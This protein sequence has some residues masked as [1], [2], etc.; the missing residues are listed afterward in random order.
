MNSDTFPSSDSLKSEINR[1]RSKLLGSSCLRSESRESGTGS[2][3]LNKAESACE[4]RDQIHTGTERKLPLDLDENEWVR[5]TSKV[6]SF[7]SSKPKEPCD[8][9]N[10]SANQAPNS[11]C[12][13]ENI[14][15]HES[16]YPEN[17]TC[18]S[19]DSHFGKSST[20]ILETQ[21]KKQSEEDSPHAN[22]ATNWSHAEPSL[23]S[24]EVSV[25]GHQQ[26][27]QFFSLPAH[28]KERIFETHQKESGEA[29]PL[30]RNKDYL[31]RSTYNLS[32]SPISVIALK[33]ASNG[34]CKCGEMLLDKAV[35]EEKL[36]AILK[37]EEKDTPLLT[38]FE[39]NTSLKTET[40]KNSL[41][42]PPK[43]NGLD[44]TL[45]EQERPAARRRLSKTIQ[46]LQEKIQKEIESNENISLNEKE[47]QKR[48]PEPKRIPTKL[49]SR[50]VRER[51]RRR[52]K[53]RIGFKVL[54][55]SHKH[56]QVQI[57]ER[58][59]RQWMGVGNCV[60]YDSR[61]IVSSNCSQ[62]NSLAH[63]RALTLA[64]EEGERALE[65]PEEG[66]EHLTKPADVTTINSNQTSTNADM[67]K[68]FHSQSNG[69]PDCNSDKY[70]PTYEC[71][72]D[73]K[74]PVLG[75][76][77]KVTHGENTLN[78]SPELGN[79][80][81]N[82]SLIPPTYERSRCIRR[83]S[84]HTDRRIRPPTPH[85]D[86]C[87]S[88]TNSKIP[89]SQ[90]R[91]RA[92][93]RKRVFGGSM[94]FKS[95][96][97]SA[98]SVKNIQRKSNDISGESS[99]TKSDFRDNMRT[100]K[101]F[102]AASKQQRKLTTN[103]SPRKKS[104]NTLQ[105]QTISASSKDAG[106]RDSVET[107]CSDVS[108]T[109]RESSARTESSSS[110]YSKDTSSSHNDLAPAHWDGQLSPEAR[111][112]RDVAGG[113]SRRRPGADRASNNRRYVD[114]QALVD[115]K[116][117]LP[118]QL[119]FCKGQIIKQML[120]SSFDSTEGMSYGYYRAGPFKRKKKGLFPSSCVTHVSH[121]QGIKD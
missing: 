38:P 73:T 70:S 79:G 67:S 105:N 7:G 5:E 60:T 69:S 108:T 54:Q 11:I 112:A 95:Q 76:V 22:R 115:F 93:S 83:S 116:G 18:E 64:R 77:Y 82:G 109:T 19:I 53:S 97:L 20:T 39:Q 113:V 6:E 21:L 26:R 92:A 46:Q 17:H 80:E 65:E 91:C 90:P 119:N 118:G 37:L 25:S 84:F 102:I 110:W 87:D 41:D 71:I 33:T 34:L 55:S 40:E 85:S 89:F 24:V 42:V 59:Y 101:L 86:F 78:T 48:N 8:S 62:D 28:S 88:A 3:E 58:P 94:G 45:R 51:S 14:M 56:P 30:C 81:D 50:F 31:I 16:K 23:T 47:T 29:R 43:C 27:S 15:N 96:T 49:T 74:K 72:G 12:L 32:K 107:L 117:T 121:G 120:S 57:K 99:P 4:S 66:K 61:Y 2:P 111:L 104:V 106:H 9:E 13:E 103:A 114:V 10:K 36:A 100:P 35:P 68:D 98:S 52:S 44:A 63:G 75:K 1:V